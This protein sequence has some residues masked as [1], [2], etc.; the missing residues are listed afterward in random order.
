MRSAFKE[1]KESKCAR[2]KLNC[3]PMESAEPTPT[4]PASTDAHERELKRREWNSGVGVE[5]N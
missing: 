1:T 2:D 4:P 3:F 5:K